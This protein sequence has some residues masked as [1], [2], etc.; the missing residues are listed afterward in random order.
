MLQEAG[1]QDFILPMGYNEPW[2][3]KMLFNSEGGYNT[4]A[5]HDWEQL[6]EAQKGDIYTITMPT[7]CREAD[8][9]QVQ[10][11]SPVT[12]QAGHSY[13]FSVSLQADKAVSGISVALCEN[14]DDDICIYQI[15]TNL[16]AGTKKF[17]S[18]SNLTGTD[19][20][21]AK[22]AFRFPTAEDDVSIAISGLSIYD[23][24]EGR[25][26]WTGCSFYNWC[27]YA[28]EWG[29]RIPDPQIEGRTETLSWTRP[30]YDDT[31]WSEAPIPIGR[32]DGSFIQAGSDAPSPSRKYTPSRAT[33]STSSTMTTTASGSTAHSSTRQTTGPSAPKPSSWRFLPNCCKE[34][35]TSLQPTYSR[36]GAASS[37]TA[38]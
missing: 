7:A 22:I 2:T 10:F 20:G 15:E 23:T 30:L 5:N 36:T 37:T 3:G 11:K 35:A 19:I 13:R 18:K 38:D 27:F 9:G 21:D 1:A 26:L 24:T 17:I 31:D 33:C 29:N 6:Y 28:D 12:L 25:E 32:P 14:E 8:Y 4:G 16:S 34:A